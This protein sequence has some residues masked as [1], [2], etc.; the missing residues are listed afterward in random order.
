[1]NVRTF[2]VFSAHL[3][4]MGK[5]EMLGERN[6]VEKYSGDRGEA[7]CR[8]RESN[9][10]V[11]CWTQDFK[12]CASTS[13]AISAN[14]FKNGTRRYNALTEVPMSAAGFFITSAL[15]AERRETQVL[16]AGQRGDE[17]SAATEF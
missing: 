1:M 14:G 17:C 16:Q 7:W 11:H 5:T 3:F 13:S 2:E 12:S 6:D 8:K 4:F 15:N 9:P 10:H